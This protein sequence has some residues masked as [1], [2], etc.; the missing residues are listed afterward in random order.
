MQIKS[1]FSD[2]EALE[3][4]GQKILEKKVSHEKKC[5][6]IKENSN[7]IRPHKFTGS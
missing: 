6:K 5:Q 4:G 1:Y 2:D 3:K 7:K